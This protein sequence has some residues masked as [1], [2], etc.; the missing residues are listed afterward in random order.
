MRVFSLSTAPL[1]GNGL[2]GTDCHDDVGLQADQLVRERSYPIDV[3]AAPT[4]VHPHVAAI[5]PTQ[6]R[7]RLRERRDVS[8]RPGVV[9]V[10]PREHAD[11]PHAV[12]LLRA[13]RERPR[14]R[15]A[16]KREELAPPDT[17]HGLPTRQM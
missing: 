6:V 7:K 15:A 1:D 5:A 10:E 3:S 11:A 2:R 8:L 4:K 16:E 12:A 13:C 17:K 14:R 9:F